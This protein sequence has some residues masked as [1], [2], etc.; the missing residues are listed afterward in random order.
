LRVTGGSR[1]KYL[2][3]DTRR[4]SVDDEDRIHGNHAVGRGALLRR[5]AA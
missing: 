1:V 3:F 5:A 4:T 2:E